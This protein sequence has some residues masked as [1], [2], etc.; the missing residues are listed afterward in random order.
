MVCY[1]GCTTNSSVATKTDAVNCYNTEPTANCTKSGN[2][3]IRITYLAKVSGTKTFTTKNETQTYVIP[4]TGNYKIEVWGAQGGGRTSGSQYGGYGSYSVGTINLT[5]NTT[6]YINVGS[7]GGDASTPTGG[8]GGYNGGGTGGNAYQ[9]SLYGGG[10]GGGA[11]SVALSTGTL[12]ELGQANKQNDVIIVAGG[13]GGSGNE[14]TIGHAG[15]KQSLTV[16]AMSGGNTLSSPYINPATQSTGYAFGLGQNGRTSTSGYS[17][18]G[19]GAGGGG[20]GYYGGYASSNNGT[21]TAIAGTGGSGYIGY[22][23]LTN[24]KMVCYTG[25]TA[26]S[27]TSTYTVVNS[28][29][30]ET[31]SPDCSKIGDGFV[32]IT[33]LDNNYESLSSKIVAGTSGTHNSYAYQIVSEGDGTRYE[34]K[35]PANYVCFSSSCTNDTLYRI[36][37]VFTEMV[38]TT[39]NGTADTNQSVIK[40]TK[41]VASES[42][43]YSTSNNNNWANASLNT[44]LNGTWAKPYNNILTVRWY[45]KAPTSAAYSASDWLSYERNGS[46][47]SGYPQYIDSKIA[48]PYASDFGYGALSSQCGR[49]TSLGYGGYNNG[50]YQYT[51]LFD[52]N[53]D[54]YYYYLITP[55]PSDTNHAYYVDGYGYVA[56]SYGSNYVSSEFRVKPTFYLSIDTQITG[57]TG[58]KVDPY[59]IY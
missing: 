51:W 2:G 16:Y 50:C 19:E 27:N 7:K 52:Q 59:L 9:N 25:C 38:D 30:N 36:V 24:K 54:H 1:T 11:S 10:G 56:Y 34:G 40:I 55:Y 37:G 17:N 5:K 42:R 28:C 47:Y 4:K 41:E 26:D 32:K 23:T 39:G 46:V 43:A 14:T 44:Y 12:Y 49:S 22:S 29:A 3:H 35:D 6:L 13:G 33:L 57:G 21:S 8:A 53:N 18:G 31:A 45:L 48:L 58:T 15:G 20:G